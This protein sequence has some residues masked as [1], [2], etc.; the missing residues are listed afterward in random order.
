LS[1]LVALGQVLA[2]VGTNLL[3]G[4][5]QSWRDQAEAAHDLQTRVAHEPALREELD[6]IIEKLGAISLAKAEL[7]EKECHGLS[8][9]SSRN[10]RN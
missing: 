5:L 7:S 8:T 6:V 1:A 10:C 3:A 2:G 4:G 9:R